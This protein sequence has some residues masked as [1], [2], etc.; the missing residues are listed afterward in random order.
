MYERYT[1][2]HTCGT[3]SAP[4]PR[5]NLP[6]NA[7][8]LDAVA[9]FKI[10]PTDHPTTW[11][12]NYCPCSNGEPIVKGKDFDESHANT[13]S[14]ESIRFLALASI[15]RFRVFGL[16][17]SNAFQSTPLEDTRTTP[18]IYMKCPPFYLEWFNMA[19][20][21]LKIDKSHG[22]FVIQ[23]LVYIQDTPP[24]SH[25]VYILLIHLLAQI[26][27]YPTS[28]NVG[29]LV[30]VEDRDVMFLAVE[31]DDILV[32][33]N[34]VS[35]EKRIVKQIQSPFQVTVQEGKVIEFLNYRIIQSV[36]GISVNQTA[37]ILEML[38]NFLPNEKCKNTTTPLSSDKQYNEE[39]YLS[40][41]ATPAEPKSLE[42][43]FGHKFSSIC[44]TLLHVAT[45]S[46]PDIT[47][48]RNRLIVFQSGPN[49]TVLLLKVFFKS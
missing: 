14:C 3:W 28:V 29:V 42:K 15:F 34:S 49:R 39:V 7:T 23:L 36:H 10:K 9:T 17:I 8:I 1:R 33:T 45:A 43:E 31:T 47:N 32:C 30:I 41:P 37:H 46:R 11:N 19:F 26:K 16:D 20:K 12:L 48:A 18:P 21:K 25:E 24:T 6:P 5:K 4:I 35:L 40:L 13:A 2:F 38:D 22:P 27:I 44:G